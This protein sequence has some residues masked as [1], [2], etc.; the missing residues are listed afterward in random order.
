[1][2]EKFKGEREP[3]G[4]SLIKQ[5]Y[6]AMKAAADEVHRLQ[7]ELEGAGFDFSKPMDEKTRESL[8][9]IN[10]RMAEAHIVWDLA[11]EEFRKAFEEYMERK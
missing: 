10:E 4:E 7:Q 2:A 3:G 8:R 1:M 9:V 6:E 11:Q 5:K